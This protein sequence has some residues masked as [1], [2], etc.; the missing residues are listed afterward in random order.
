VHS[1]KTVHIDGITAVSRGS[2]MIEITFHAVL[3]TAEKVA[4]RVGYDFRYISEG[5]DEPREQQQCSNWHNSIEGEMVPGCIVGTILH[6]LGVPL[7]RM[8]KS[9]LANDLIY[10]LQRQGI[11]GEVDKRTRCF[12]SVMQAAQDNGATW[13]SAVRT[14]EVAIDLQ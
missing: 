3:R 1:L 6:E 12:L 10:Y 4:R 5:R 7:E 8:S 2:E 9:A 14:A 13:H 11:I